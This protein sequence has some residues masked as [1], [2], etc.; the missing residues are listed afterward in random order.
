MSKLFASPRGEAKE[1]SLGFR[2]DRR[3]IY[4][5]MCKARVAMR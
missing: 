1:N 3:V 5:S 2:D 4:I